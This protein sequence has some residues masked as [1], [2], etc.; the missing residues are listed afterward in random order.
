VEVLKVIAGRCGFVVLACRVYG[1]DH[2]FVSAPLSIGILV[3]VCVL[4]CNSA[5]ALFLEFVQL[6]LWFWGGQ[7][8]SAGYAVRTAGDV[9]STKIEEY[10]NRC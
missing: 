10:I 4:K 9:T 8:W 2:V 1:G 3:M 6:K 5:R 7:L